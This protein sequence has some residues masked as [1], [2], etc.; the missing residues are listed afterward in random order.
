MPTAPELLAELHRLRSALEAIS[1]D[2]D[3][4]DCRD[5]IP[6]Q[7]A[8]KNLPSRPAR[9]VESFVDNFQFAIKQ[10]KHS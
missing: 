4:L 9:T 3:A 8:I 7:H 1:A 5:H 6:L 2:I 10:H